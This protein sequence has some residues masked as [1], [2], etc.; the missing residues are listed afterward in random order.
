MEFESSSQIL[1]RQIQ[2]VGVAQV[3]FEALLKNPRNSRDGVRKVGLCILAVKGGKKQISNIA[4][5]QQRASATDGRQLNRVFDDASSAQDCPDFEEMGPR[6]PDRAPAPPLEWASAWRPR[7]PAA[8][9]MAIDKGNER[10]DVTAQPKLL[11]MSFLVALLL[12]PCFS[13]FFL[14]PFFS[15]PFQYLRAQMT[16]FEFRKWIIKPLRNP[17]AKMDPLWNLIVNNVKFICP[18]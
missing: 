18:V 6:R 12:S 15:D 14:I 13:S 17:G 16:L 11:L 8:L 4:A 3:I 2:D 9:F 10:S 1:R 5:Q 7:V